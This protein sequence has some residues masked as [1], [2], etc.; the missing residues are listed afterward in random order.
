MAWGKTTHG[1]VLEEKQRLSAQIK[2]KIK[3]LKETTEKTLSKL[4]ET[5]SK[6]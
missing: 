2:K 1:L 3:V 6:L 4:E 5:L